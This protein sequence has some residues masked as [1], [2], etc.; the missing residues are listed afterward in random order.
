MDWDG[1]GAAGASNDG[2]TTT[3][4]WTIDILGNCLAVGVGVDGVGDFDPAVAC[5]GVPMTLVD[6]QTSGGHYSALFLLLNPGT[7]TRASA[8]TGLPGGGVRAG[9]ASLSFTGWGGTADTPVKT[10]NTGTD[11]TSGA[12]SSDAGDTVVNVLSA[13]GSSTLSQLVTTGDGHTH[14]EH[15]NNDGA[16]LCVALGY[17]NGSGGDVTPG[18][19]WG[20]AG[21]QSASMIAANLNKAGRRFILH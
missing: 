15:A 1:S 11:I 7:G 2:T 18:W 9:G 12:V 5:E 20:A 19:S 8:V 16:G 21:S 3:M 13:N 6:E 17:T 14:P 10:T 4:D